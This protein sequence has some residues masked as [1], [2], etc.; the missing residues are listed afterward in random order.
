MVDL[1]L[2][3]VQSGFQSSSKVPYSS[4]NKVSH[5]LI[6]LDTCLNRLESQIYQILLYDDDFPRL[7]RNLDKVEDLYD[8]S[9]L[10]VGNRLVNN[11]EFQGRFVDEPTD[12]LYFGNLTYDITTQKQ[13]D[14]AKIDT[15]ATV[16]DNFYAALFKRYE[17]NP[18][19]VSHVDG[20]VTTKF[21]QP[22]WPFGF[23]FIPNYTTTRAFLTTCSRLEETSFSIQLQHK[24]P[25]HIQRV[26]E[27]IDDL[28][29]YCKFTLTGKRFTTLQWQSNDLIELEPE[30]WQG[31][32]SF[33]LTLEKDIV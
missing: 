5:T 26:I 8:W 27:L 21:G 2:E 16:A 22:D 12:G 30:F 28:Y 33:N 10:E 32:V 13:F 24:D 1:E 4:L 23:L 7:L 3:L 20:F 25:D 19:L 15:V 18:N 11:V 17:D 31:S 29:S 6:N 9:T 14:P